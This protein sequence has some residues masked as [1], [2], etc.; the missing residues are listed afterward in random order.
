MEVDFV[1]GDVEVAIEA[2]A[3]ARVTS[4]HLRGLREIGQDHPRVKRR[5]LVSLEERPR[6]TEDGIESC[7]TRFSPSGCG[8]VI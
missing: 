4:D 5:L 3:S 2:K 8:A 6:K 1:V 7:P